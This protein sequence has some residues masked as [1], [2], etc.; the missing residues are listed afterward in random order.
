M[1]GTNYDPYVF[2]FQMPLGSSG[3]CAVVTVEKYYDDVDIERTKIISRGYNIG[4]DESDC[5]E[6]SPRRVE[7]ALQLIY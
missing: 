5:D 4:W 7:R 3:V 1:K 6:S 2:S